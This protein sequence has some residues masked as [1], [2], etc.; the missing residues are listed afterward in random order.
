M[1]INVHD[2]HAYPGCGVTIVEGERRGRK[3]IVEFSD[4]SV[5][6]ARYRRLGANQLD[7]QVDPYTTQR[8]TSIGARRWRLRRG[9]RGHWKVSAKLP[10]RS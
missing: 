8:G 7:L 3:A 5:T 10:F 2:T 4:G 6:P 1:Q 9:E